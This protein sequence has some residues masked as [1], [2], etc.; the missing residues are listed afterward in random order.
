MQRKIADYR[1]LK[2]YS[3]N[4][5]ADEVMMMTRNGYELWGGPFTGGDYFY[6]A[7]VKYEEDGVVG[8]E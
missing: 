6:Q 4:S 3:S 2:S 1:V 8:V 5:M 7:V